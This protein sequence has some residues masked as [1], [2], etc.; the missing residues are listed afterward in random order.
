MPPLSI[1]S[2][3]GRVDALVSTAMLRGGLV[4][5]LLLS[6]AATASSTRSG[7]KTGLSPI[8][9]RRQVCNNPRL[10]PNRRATS[11]TLTPGRALS[12]TIAAAAQSR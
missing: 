2:V 8:A 11:A 3:P 12:A 9:W 6:V 5:S 4:R 1:S 7:T 10:T